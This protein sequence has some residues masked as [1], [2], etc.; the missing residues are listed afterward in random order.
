[1]FS[2]SITSSSASNYTTATSTDYVWSNNTGTTSVS[3]NY[4]WVNQD[5]ITATASPYYSN[6]DIIEDCVK[7]YLIEEKDKEKNNMSDTFSFGP[8][9]SFNVRFSTYG[10]ALANKNGKWVS[11]DKVNHKLI[12]VEVFNINVDAK[13]VF[14]KLPKATN[15]VIAGDIIIH[16]GKPMFVEK[17]R[18][19]GKFEVIDPYE[20]IAVTVLPLSSPFGFD[21]TECLVS[22]ID[23][24]P[25]ADENNPFGNLLPLM[26]AEKGDNNAMALVMMMDKNLD[27]I[28]PM[29]LLL[30]NGKDNSNL[31]TYLLMQMMKKNKKKKKTVPAEDIQYIQL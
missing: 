5:P 7:K 11:Y 10:I 15:Q 14:Y 21:F 17:V 4:I 23:C 6:R 25:A 3:S 26:L 8:L 9:D 20:G 12:D 28:D 16:N 18:E 2:I 22:L 27:D 31:S 30:F 1:M 13:K 19:D 29:M 24:M